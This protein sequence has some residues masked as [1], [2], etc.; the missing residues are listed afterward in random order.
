[1]GSGSFTDRDLRT[2]AMSSFIIYLYMD[3]E[4]QREQIIFRAWPV[5][6][7]SRCGLWVTQTRS[8]RFLPFARFDSTGR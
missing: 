8:V 3:A 7:F 4:P 1:M 2:N 5:S 6:L